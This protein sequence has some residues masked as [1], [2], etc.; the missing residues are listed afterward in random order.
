MKLAGRINK[1]LISN[2][3]NTPTGVFLFY[4]ILRKQKCKNFALSRTANHVPDPYRSGMSGLPGSGSGFLM[5]SIESITWFLLALAHL[6][7]VANIK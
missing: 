1:H 3:S 6:T 2:F 7:L 4:H 5:R